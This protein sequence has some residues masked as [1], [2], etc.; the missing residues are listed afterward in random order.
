MVVVFVVVL[1]V[2]LLVPVTKLI[3]DAAAAFVLINGVMNSATRASKGF[4]EESAL[5]L[6]ANFFAFLKINAGSGD[7]TPSSSSSSFR[8]A[9]AVVRTKMTEGTPTNSFRAL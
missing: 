8:G 4:G 2:L 6:D 1:V 5:E 3:A 9:V 7:R